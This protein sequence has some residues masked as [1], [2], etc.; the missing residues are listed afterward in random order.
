V[1]AVGRHTAYGLTIESQ[2]PIPEMPPA[3]GARAADVVVRIGT[4][5]DHLEGAL[6]AAE[7]YEASADE[8]LL[9]ISGVARYLVTRGNE[10]IVEPDL[11]ADEHDIRVFLLGTCMGALLHQRGALVLHASGFG[12]PDGAVL[13]AGRSG[14]G[15]ST[16]LAEMIDRGFDMM[17]DDVAGVFPA[18]DDGLVLQPSYPRTRMWADAADHLGVET[19][20]LQRT[21]SHM[22]KFERQLPDRFWDRPSPIRRIYHLAGSRGDELSLTPVPQIHVVPIVVNNTYRQVFLD[23]F[24]IRRRHFE[25]ASRVARTVPV[26]QVVRPS[27]TFRLA[28]LAG[29][30]LADLG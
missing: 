13:F 28:E 27:D 5:P 12:T 9:R 6:L 14:A 8:M 3:S 25:L 20:R 16:L 26:V 18:D 15:K 23:G 24:D 1:N 29:M 19:D 17:V 7:N 4:V 21:R 11:D 30:I 10:V 2:L 22:D